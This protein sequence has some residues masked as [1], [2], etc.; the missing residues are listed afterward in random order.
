MGRR[1]KGR[2]VSGW[3]VVDK[4]VGATST[5][6]VGKARWAL[7]ARKAG[8]AG[9]LDPA[10]S[11]VL[12][13]AVGEATKTAQY[14]TDSLK[15]YEF[16]VRLG[17]ATDTD[18]AE[19]ARIAAS[20]LRPGDDEIRQA[21]MQFEGRIMQTPPIYSAVKV[22]GQRAYRLAREGRDVELDARPLWVERIEMT[23]RPD[24]DRAVVE[25]VCGKGGYV[26]AVARDLGDALGCHG[27]VERLRRLWSGPFAAAD[28]IG[29][30]EI[31]AFAGS[32][33][34]DA[35][36]LPL[37]A[38]LA[39]LPEAACRPEGAARLRNGNPAEVTAPGLEYGDE[40]WAS[41]DGRA[42]AVGRYRAGLLHPTR[43]F[44]DPHAAA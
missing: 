15:C 6:V 9:T 33:D 26:R 25:M 2:D 16:T 4:P 30:E 14:V 43:V 24:P 38:G 40:C 36:L 27:H 20:D 21:L 41:Q 13:V 18:D 17:I 34:L 39:G 8:H 29:L 10:A 19:G 23:G 5:S 11:G 22:D 7:Q 3:L 42:V 44:V 1:R 28:G 35:R 32:P 12:C 37:E 31:D